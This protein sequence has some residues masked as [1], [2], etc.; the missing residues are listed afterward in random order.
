[1]YRSVQRTPRPEGSQSLLTSWPKSDSL[2][3]D[4]H[5]I[6]LWGVSG[7]GTLLAVGLASRQVRC[8]V[9]LYP[10]VDI[11]QILPRFPDPARDSVRRLLSAVDLPDSI[12]AAPRLLLVRA[13]LDQPS[14]NASIDSVVRHALDRNRSIELIN[15]P[16]GHHA[17]D[18]ID[19]TEE[20]R[21]ILLR[22]MQ[23]VSTN[24][25]RS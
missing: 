10:F 5:R 22:A 18:L 16:T 7:G 17:F 9:G 20:S 14:L 21:A 23:F 13:G 8:I 15:H 12:A 6:C 1:M 25:H 24:L 19:D 2:G 3:I 11:R 4:P